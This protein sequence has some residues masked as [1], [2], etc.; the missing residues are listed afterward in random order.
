MLSI[1]EFLLG[2]AKSEDRDERTRL[3]AEVERHRLRTMTVVS[4]LGIET[5]TR[6]GVCPKEDTQPC[7]VLRTIALPYAEHPSYQQ[8]W[9]LL[10]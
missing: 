10:T 3:R 9:S 8:E 1:H 5:I 4:H 6:C 7:T 2:L